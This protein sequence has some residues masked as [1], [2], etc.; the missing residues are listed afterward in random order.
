MCVCVC[1]SARARARARARVRA[2]RHDSYV[3]CCSYAGYI[4][5]LINVKTALLLGQ[6]VGPCMTVIIPKAN[7]IRL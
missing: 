5:V 3:C 4:R 2:R 1:V 6:S 7:R